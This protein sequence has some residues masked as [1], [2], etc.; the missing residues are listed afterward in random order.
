MI[1]T[2]LLSPPISGGILD[3]DSV[4]TKKLPG[5]HSVVPEPVNLPPAPQGPWAIVPSVAQLPTKYS[6]FFTSGPGGP[7]IWATADNAIKITNNIKA[8]FR[9]TLCSLQA[10]IS[11]GPPSLA[12]QGCAH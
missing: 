1:I 11:S 12:R 2:A 7:P 5:N 10:G 3:S 6:S 8:I 9:F 4:L